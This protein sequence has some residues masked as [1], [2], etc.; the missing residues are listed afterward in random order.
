MG[1][2]IFKITC[3]P[4]AVEVVPQP[5]V[6]TDHIKVKKPRT[7]VGGNVV[8][9][10]GVSFGS[11]ISYTVMAGYVKRV[12][13]YVK[14]KSSFSS[15]AKGIIQGDVDDAFYNGNANKGRFSAYGGVLGRIHPVLYLYVGVGYGNKWLEWYTVDNKPV[16][17]QSASYSGMDPEFGLLLKTK[18]FAIGGGLNCLLGKGHANLEGSVSVG[19]M[20]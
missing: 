15:K 16:E 8:L 18:V 9:L 13:G 19:V 3:T 12:G 2:F 7:A 1:T 10:P 20:F 4:S 17:I 14:V 6:K 11:A 5:V